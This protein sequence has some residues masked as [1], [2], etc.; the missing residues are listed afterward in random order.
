MITR[1][2]LQNEIESIKERLMDLE[3]PILYNV[4]DR[5]YYDDNEWKVINIIRPY[6]MPYGFVVYYKLC[7]DSR[8]I[9]DLVKQDDIEKQL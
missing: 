3:Y 4:G 9:K 6:I 1:K 5:V 7:S 8:G 2:S